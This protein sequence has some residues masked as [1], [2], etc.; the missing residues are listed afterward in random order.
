MHIRTRSLSV[1]VALSTLVFS[2]LAM[3]TNGYLPHGVGAKNKA[4]AGAG[5]AMPEDAIA[6]V[7]NPATAVFLGNRMDAGV[8]ALMP[9]RNFTTLFSGSNGEGNTFSFGNVDTDSDK[10]IFFLPELAGTHQLQNGSAFA[11]AFYTRGGVGGSY[12]GGSATFDPDAGG[13][14]G[15]TTLPGTYGDGTASLELTQALVDITWAKK[16]GDRTSFGISAVLAAQSLDVKGLGGFSKYTETFASSN[17]AAVP[18]NLSGNGSDVNYGAGLKL[19]V[20]RLLGEH[21][22]FGIMYQTAIEIGASADY[23]D[24][25]ADG[26]KLD[27]PAWF[28]MGLTWQASDRLS[29][30]IDT[31]KIWYAQVD[32][33]GNSFTNIYDCPTAGLGGTDT[34]RCLGGKNGPGFGWKNVPVYSLGSSWKMNDR[35]ALYAGVSIAD[36]PVAYIENTFNIPVFN[37]TEA[38]YTAGISRRLRNGNELTLSLMYSEEESLEY[39]N[40]LDASQVLRLT[41]DQFDFQLSYSWG[42]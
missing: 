5:V 12:K 30:S 19:G 35:W 8:S 42:L 1:T 22:S 7:S 26:G 18:E 36:Q 6:I 10:D 39:L 38:H 14:L 3:A 37:L 40:Q 27:I 33:W 9:N 29:F 23:A 2:Q 28:K 31:Q 41:T 11:W 15:I 17:G 21:F 25:L 13:P 32:A 24:L 34:D 20:H 16:L 4:M